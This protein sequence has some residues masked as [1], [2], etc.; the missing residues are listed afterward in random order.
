M[1]GFGFSLVMGE[2]S[3]E[4]DTHSLALS[5][6]RSVQ[7]ADRV[8]EFHGPVRSAV[9][10][11][12]GDAPHQPLGPNGGTRQEGHVHPL[13]LGPVTSHLEPRV[14][15]IDQGRPTASG[16]DRRSGAVIAGAARSPEPEW[17]TMDTSRR[18]KFVDA[19]LVTREG[20]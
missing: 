17:R 2:L 12:Y 6:T 14:V 7:A 19:V 5:V 1:F 11:P 8:V 9:C 20:K 10:G 3:D 4:G 15:Q 18:G 13:Q 16:C